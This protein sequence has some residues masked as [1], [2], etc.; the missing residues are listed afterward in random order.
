[1]LL[2]EV[3]NPHS[4]SGLYDFEVR[5]VELDLAIMFGNTESVENFVE[6]S[7]R[8]VVSNPTIPDYLA[9]LD[10]YEFMG[11]EAMLQATLSEAIFWFPNNKTLLNY[12]FRTE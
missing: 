8:R 7:S 2:N 5:R 3:R 6:W 10:A 1:M 9:L 12:E 4:M 11:D